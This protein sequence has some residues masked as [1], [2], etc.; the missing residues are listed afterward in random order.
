MNKFQKYILKL[1][2][3]LSIVFVVIGVIEIKEG[4][5]ELK[6]Q[7]EINEIIFEQEYIN[8]C[9]EDSLRQVE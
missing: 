2:I 5:K 6:K 9:L 7:I 4:I 8:F 3:C 1:T